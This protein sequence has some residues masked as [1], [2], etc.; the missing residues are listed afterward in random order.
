MINRNFELLL[1]RIIDSNEVVDYKR[2]AKLLKGIKHSCVCTGNGGSR[3]VSQ[4]AQRVLEQK[5]DIIAVDMEPRDVLYTNLKKYK[6]ICAFTYGGHNEGI[7]KALNKAGC[8]KLNRYAL[9]N[10]DSKLK[11]ILGSNPK[12]DFI[13]NYNG[14]L[15]KEVSFISIASTLIPMSLL[16]RYYLDNID[17]NYYELLCDIYIK[18]CHGISSKQDTNESLQNY[19]GI[20]NICDSLD[21][22]D[23]AQLFK[24]NSF[25]EVMTGD[26][27]YTASKIIESNFV[28]AGLSVPLVHEK[29]NYCHG[30][31]TL[32]YHNTGG[33][34]IYLLNRL[35]PQEIDI[36]LWKE[37]SNLYKKII[38]LKTSNE[39]VII[40][41]FELALQAM[42]LSKKIASSLNVDLS[43]VNYA[44]AV[45]KLYKF[46]GE[47]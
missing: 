45:K 33:V 7:N 2:M 41:E 47:M 19:F 38:V 8:S 29:Y 13:I 9:T 15:N 22:I 1:P 39:D 20:K 37:L 23:Y 36:V 35:K 46:K 17:T 4:Y 21:T 32:A 14:N 27:T 31:S 24:I 25:V 16:L 12:M 43:K 40:G 30:R 11:Y 10:D 6:N 28:E 5:N 34:L 44:P 26:N 18:N 3:A 42:I